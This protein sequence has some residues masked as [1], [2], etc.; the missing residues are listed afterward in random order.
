MRNT[1]PNASNG[2]KISDD[3]YD[4]SKKF[5]YATKNGS[6]NKSMSNKSKIQ[7]DKVFRS[8]MHPIQE[9]QQP[10]KTLRPSTDNTLNKSMFYLY[11]KFLHRRCHVHQIRLNK[12][13]QGHIPAL[14]MSS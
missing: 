5:Y 7:S 13:K 14:A 1:T 6:H 10:P 12:K 2:K 11:H 9:E 3:N 8:T 4:D